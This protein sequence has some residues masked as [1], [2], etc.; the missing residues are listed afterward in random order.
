MGYSPADCAPSIPS[1]RV[2]ETSVITS[3]SAL[4][5]G[6]CV[7]SVNERFSIPAAIL[8]LGI[9]ALAVVLTAAI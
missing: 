8:L 9:A 2:P 5:L 7:E 4:E 6:T 1:C 3:L